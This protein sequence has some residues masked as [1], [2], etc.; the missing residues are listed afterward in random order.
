MVVAILFLFSVDAVTARDWI[1]MTSPRGEVYSNAGIGPAKRALEQLDWMTDTFQDIG[2]PRAAAPLKILIFAS[3]KEFAEYRPTRLSSGFYQSGP[4]GD[5]ICFYSGDTRVALHEFTHSL[6]NRSTIQL[7]Q[8]LEEGLAE[9][10]STLRVDKQHVVIGTAIPEHISN[11]KLLDFLPEG[12][13]VKANRR[14]IHE[15]GP[16]LAARFYATGWALVHMLYLSPKFAPYMP[17]FVEAIDSAKVSPE[18]AFEDAFGMTIGKALGEAQA[19][20]R[21]PLLP[22]GRIARPNDDP[23]SPIA[24]AQAV[25]AVEI[26]RV[27]AELLLDSGRRD[28]AAIKYRAIAKTK[29]PASIAAQ[30]FWSLSENDI[31][32]ATRFFEK[33][34]ENPQADARL[35]FEYAMLLRE[36]GT[37]SR[38][39]VSELLERTIRLNPLHPEAHFLLGIRAT[40]EKRFIEAVERLREAVAVLPR[41]SSFWH[42]LGFAYSKTGNQAE[43]RNAAHK[44]IRIAGS[45]QEEKMARDLLASLEPERRGPAAKSVDA[46]V[47]EA[48]KNPQGDASV[49]GTLKAFVCGNPPKIEITTTRGVEEFIILNPQKLT[50]RNAAYQKIEFV[51]GELDPNRVRIEY[52]RATRDIT[53]IDFSP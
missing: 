31:P 52:L 47:S 21:Q 45:E 40:D 32:A 48:W 11:L 6:L 22:S 3:E 13:L 49:V 7:P 18:R 39:R 28:E 9:F 27:Q 33:A 1:K 5:W 16:V 34:L 4:S 46:P 29:S 35:V 44:A 43:A 14:S 2:R 51:C 19:Y 41:Q 20:I 23:E 38:A 42:A 53:S 37:A 36:S 10:F 25:D 17:A 15:E 30:A 12:D 24:E 50:L 26:A 8:W